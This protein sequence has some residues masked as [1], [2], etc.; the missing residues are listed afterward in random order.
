M[1]DQ[2]LHPYQT[3]IIQWHVHEGLSLEDIT[4]R[5]SKKG[6]PS[7][8]VQSARSTDKSANCL[9]RIIT[10]VDHMAQWNRRSSSLVVENSSQSSSQ[11]DRQALTPDPEETLRQP[12]VANA[13]QVINPQKLSR[14]PSSSAVVEMQGQGLKCHQP[15]HL[16]DTESTEETMERR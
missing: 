10:L 1:A 11:S 14:L 5:L 16:P 15:F 7:T 9:S 6:I 4:T 13:Y 2:S 3:D 8:R 12:Q